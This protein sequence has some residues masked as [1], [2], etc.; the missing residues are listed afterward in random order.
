MSR[1]CPDRPADALEHF[2]IDA[3]FGETGEKAAD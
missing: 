3:L 1:D 2:D